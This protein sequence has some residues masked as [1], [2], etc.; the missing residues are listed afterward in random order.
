MRDGPTPEPSSIWTYWGA[1]SKVLA[2]PD[3]SVGHFSII[4]A[5]RMGPFLGLPEFKIR[6]QRHSMTMGNRRLARPVQE[7]IHA[8]ERVNEYIFDH[9]G[10]PEAECEAVV[11]CAR[12]LISGYRATL[13]GAS[14]HTRQLMKHAA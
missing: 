2:L 10:L 1:T 12:E 11:F 13:Q 5:D 8:F 6:S 3:E 9:K 4:V 14:S 7:L